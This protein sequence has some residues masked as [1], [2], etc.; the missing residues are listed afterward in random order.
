MPLSPEQ[1]AR[2]DI[3]AA[4][5]ASGWIVQDR[6]EINLSAGPGVAVREF[7]MADAHGFADY[8]LFV[9]GKAVGVVEAKPAA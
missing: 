7:R 6:A 4:L 8:M 2:Q 1:R 3:D 9:E 5:E